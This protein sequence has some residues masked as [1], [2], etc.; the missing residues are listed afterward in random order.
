MGSGKTF[1]SIASFTE[2]QGKILVV[3]PAFL[4]LN[5]KK[6]FINFVKKE[7][8]IVI[9]EGKNADKVDI[10]AA[11]VVILNYAIIAKCE[12]FFKW[13]DNIVADE[14]HYLL[15]PKAARTKQFV[16]FIQKY[17]PNRLILATGTINKGKTQQWYIPLF[18]ASLNPKKTSGLVMQD[19]VDSYWTFQHKFC[20]K[21]VINV[22]GREVTQFTGLKNKE[23]LLKLIRGKV[24]KGD[25]PDLEGIELNFKDVYVD[26][27]TADDELKKAWEAF[28]DGNKIEEHIMS[29]K[30]NSAMTKCEFTIKYVKNLIE[31]GETPI[32]LYTDHLAPLDYLY[33]GL[34][35]YRI[36]KIS[37]S[38]P[39]NLRD[40]YVEQFQ[41]GELDIILATITS[42]NVGV[43]LTK[44]CNMVINDYNWLGTEMDQLYHRIFRIGQTKDC[45]I[46]NIFGSVV[47]KNILKNIKK[48]N[49]II[50][51]VME[52]I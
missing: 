17:L 50:N 21:Q 15:N 9:V 28:Q 42:L 47:D 30:S 13:A 8:N 32:C 38:I 5:W 41:N 45:I 24:I 51:S 14:A 33:K 20:F 18:L 40:K 29:A 36:A 4:K 2:M 34:N 35:K 16:K 49:K 26:Y 27:E 12:R 19:Y 23:E 31:S 44:S 37:G 52:R 43:T 6:E 25:P 3:C 46:H 11:D 7:L 1:V 22:G 10:S 39:M 48:G